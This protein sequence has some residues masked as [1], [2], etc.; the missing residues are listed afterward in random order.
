MFHKEGS[1]A[2]D[3]KNDR[4][5]YKEVTLR[6]SDRKLLLQSALQFFHTGDTTRPDQKAILEDIFSRND[7]NLFQRTCRLP[8]L[9]SNETLLVTVHLFFRSPQPTS[10]DPTSSAWPYSLYPQCIWIQLIVDARQRWD[11]P[12]VA[13]CSV[14]PPACFQNRI[15]SIPSPVSEFVCANGVK[16][17]MRVGIRALPVAPKLD[18]AVPGSARVTLVCVQ[19]NPQ[20]FAVGLL[21]PDLLASRNANDP[22]FF[23]PLGPK[24]VGITILHSYG[25]DIWRQQL[26]TAK[27][28]DRIRSAVAASSNSIT[29]RKSASAIAVVQSTPGGSTYD[30]GHYGNIGFVDGKFVQPIQYLVEPS[31]IKSVTE[32]MDAVHFL[33]T[34]N[35]NSTDLT[36]NM[37]P[38]MDCD[39][40]ILPVENDESDV[41]DGPVDSDDHSHPLC[42]D[43]VLHDAVCRALAAISP[44]RDLPMTMANFYALHVLPHRREGTIIQLKQT[45][46]KKFSNYVTEQVAAGLLMAGKHDSGTSKD[47]IGLL[48]GFDRRHVDLAPY[49][50]AH[51]EQVANAVSLGDGVEKRMVMLD[52][53]CIPNHF[54]DILKLDQNVV[55]ASN[56]TSEERRGTGFLTAKEVRVVLEDYILK[57]ELIPK[58]SPDVVLLNGP[59]T[60]VLYKRKN[61]KDTNSADLLPSTPMSL[62]RKEIV[63]MWLSHQEPAYALV[64]VPGNVVLK[65]KRGKPPTITIEVSRRQSNKYLTT[66]VGLELFDINAEEFAKDVSNR[67][68]CASSTSKVSSS[69]ADAVILQ[70][71]FA[72]EIEALLISD[73]RLTQHGGVK[74]A[75][76]FLPK[77]SILVALKKGVPARK[78]AQVPK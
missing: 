20:P 22:P 48:T 43:E 7:A 58:E 55:K 27:E 77:N 36:K 31:V 10:A 24:G 29:V 49:I 45:R 76:Y 9:W 44:K 18:G 41:M 1:S 25:D 28:L 68:A 42:A 21:H 12:G 13:L 30:A 51:K 47:P 3:L 5:P 53:Y 63:N 32:E 72:T 52:L 8:L 40:D 39:K 57:E 56:A 70:G 54:V 11:L 35:V 38:S 71:N 59:L 26:P 78:K 62:S 4:K 61:K 65:L 75:T 69:A 64:Q 17:I 60:D 33:P 23:G 14:L 19:G 74:G 2:L 16:H 66:V 67:F 34:D 50:S 46:Y 73:E 6:K 15:T 37:L